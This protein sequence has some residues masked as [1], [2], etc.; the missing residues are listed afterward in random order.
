MFNSEPHFDILQLDQSIQTKLRSEEPSTDRAFYLLDTVELLRD[1][2]QSLQTPIK[3]DFLSDSQPSD[4]PEKREL[5]TRYLDTLREYKLIDDDVRGYLR[6][7]LRSLNVHKQQCAICQSSHVTESTDFAGVMICLDC[8]NQETVMNLANSI[9]LNHN[10]SKRVNICSKYSYDKKSHFQSCINQYQGKHKT[11]IEPEVL[12]L[13]ETEL[14]RYNLV[15]HTKRTRRAKYH[16]VTK[17]HIFLFI[18]E[19]KLT[20]CYGDV[21]LIHHLITGK[22]LNDISHLTEKLLHDFDQFV[23]MHHKQFP[24]E[25]ERKNFNYQHLLYQLLMRHKYP[26][27][28]SEFNF[29][30]TVDR[31]YYHDEICRTIFENL[32][33]NYSSLF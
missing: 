9:R 2:K 14:E 21:N 18:K 20:K 11:G 8:G 23:Q 29:L 27:V 13:I 17:D 10:D 19:L 16:N 28:P 26:C 1:Y 30:K 24:N 32:G 25:F 22:P 3:V 7:E 31:K 12:Q 5:V 15:D 4:C 33:W 6:P